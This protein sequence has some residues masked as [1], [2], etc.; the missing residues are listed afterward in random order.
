MR[1][2]FI[3]MHF[4]GKIMLENKS[5]ASEGNSQG[6][7]MLV[8]CLHYSDGYEQSLIRMIIIP[9]EKYHTMTERNLWWGEQLVKET[10][11][12]NTDFCFIGA[13]TNVSRE[14]IPDF[15]S[16]Y[17]EEKFQSEYDCQTDY[18]GNEIFSVYCWLW[19]ILATGFYLFE[20]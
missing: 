17:N 15:F 4:E 10:L 20:G 3:W 6:E 19:S 13:I 16:D 8:D 5:Y 1:N 11:G 18:L 2:I 12:C 9:I 7:N 14:D